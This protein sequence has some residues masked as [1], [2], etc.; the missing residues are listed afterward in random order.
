MYRRRFRNRVRYNKRGQ[1]LYLFK[2]F[3]D[4]GLLN[5]QSLTPTFQALTFRLN[6]L[7]NSG[8]F[9]A[10]YDEY[11]INAVKISFIPQQT[12]SVSIGSINNPSN[13]RFFSAIDYNDAG[14]PTSVDD[15]RQYQT[16]KYT[17]IFRTHKRYI[18]KPKIVDNSS[19]VRT[20]WI[21]TTSPATLHYGL[22][23]AV[24]PMLSSTTTSL[25][26]RV[27]CKFYMSFRQ[28]K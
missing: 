16:A 5:V 25:D 1:K 4:F 28:V 21:A 20:A 10:L 23:I 3:V 14:L 15:L 11:R 8:E 7:P 9:T 17:S 26:F 22:K 12:Q 13:V 2:R 18:Y 6:Q 27:E 19:T 24:E